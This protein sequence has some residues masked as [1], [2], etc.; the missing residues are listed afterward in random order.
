MPHPRK[1]Y[2]DACRAAVLADAAFAGVRFLPAWGK[3]EDDDAL[4]AFTVATPSE[5]TALRTGRSVN[6]TTDVLVAMKLAGGDNIEDL[7]DVYAS[8]LER[9][10]LPALAAL[11][12]VA[13]LV[14][15][16][17]KFDFGGKRRVG[18]VMLRF[19]A[20]RFTAEGSQD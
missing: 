6:R 10:C 20:V 4:P 19:E 2:R 17:V 7:L 11:C 18:D 16:D 5:R 14:E 9:V 3:P 8:D 1:A 13:Q 15:T 12:E